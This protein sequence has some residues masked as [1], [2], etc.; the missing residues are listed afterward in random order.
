MIPTFPYFQLL[1]LASLVG[2]LGL[3]A[4]SY[5]DTYDPRSG[6][7]EQH[8]IGTVRV[9]DSQQRLLYRIRKSLFEGIAETDCL[10][11]SEE[12][13]SQTTPRKS[14]KLSPKLT[15]PDAAR[16]VTLK[17][18]ASGSSKPPAKIHIA[19]DYYTNS[20]SGLP[21]SSST[22]GNSQ[23]LASSSTQRF[24][25]ADDSHFPTSNTSNSPVPA[26]NASTNQ[27]PPL[28]A[29]Q[30]SVL[31]QHLSKPQSAVTTIP[32]HPHPPLKRWPNDYTV[33]ELTAGFHAMDTLIV[34]SP[35]GAPLTQ[36][37]A[38]ERVFGSRYV[39]STVCRH[40]GVWRKAQG[41]LREQFEAMGS[42][43]RACWGEFVRRF[44]GR[45]SAKIAHQSQQIAVQAQAP[46]QGG[47][48]PA[49]L[50]SPGI[51]L[52]RGGG[53]TANH[54]SGEHGGGAETDVQA[55]ISEEKGVDAGPIMDSLQK[56]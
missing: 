45:P 18:S 19:N 28:Y 42:D 7:W 5:L 36:R 8:T 55:A 1:R 13:Q 22:L 37:A 44:E 15:V 14:P 48:G 23:A 33:S 25:D 43:E 54:R 35:T 34:Q 39:K 17:R 10:G 11:L 24:D 38:F 21:S 52:F 47:L 56:P 6:K 12:V 20:P 4:G 31:P 50:P 29:P 30:S 9:V 40:R 16:K 27:Q 2:D 32:Y 26:P 51:V 53:N 49:V 46:A 3:T 41:P